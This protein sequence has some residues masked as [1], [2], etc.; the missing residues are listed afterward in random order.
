MNTRSVAFDIQHGL[1]TELQMAF[2]LLPDELRVAVAEQLVRLTAT[3]GL[4]LEEE[5]RATCGSFAALSSCCRSV[6]RALRESSIYEEVACRAKARASPQDWTSCSPFAL[7]CEREESTRQLVRTLDAGVSSLATHCASNHCQAARKSLNRDFLAC[8]TELAH[9]CARQVVLTGSR[10]FLYCTGDR[11]GSTS[12]WI[13]A[14]DMTGTTVWSP[15]SELRQVARV[16]LSEP[17]IAMRADESLLVFSTQ[18]GVWGW[19]SE[20]QPWRISAPVE[21]MLVSDF[22]VSRGQP[23]LM[24]CS[25]DV[26]TNLFLHEVDA[27]VRSVA[28]HLEEQTVT[29]YANETSGV[30][31]ALR[32]S[33]DG[34]T[35]LT[36]ASR[37]FERAAVQVLDVDEDSEEVL[38]TEHGQTVAYCLSPGAQSACVFTLGINAMVSVFVRLGKDSWTRA[39][40]VRVPE[41]PCAFGASWPS[42]SKRTTEAV[43]SSCGSKVLFYGPRITPRPAICSLDM[44]RITRR[45]AVRVRVKCC[46]HEALPRSIRLSHAGILMQTHRGALVIRRSPHVA[47]LRL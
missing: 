25:E 41:Q 23:R 15:S 37:A 17:L 45:R 34:S 36:M 40:Y 11:K 6:N 39:F 16:E 7:Q 42:V 22:W 14:A 28:V 9:S 33:A 12:K 30:Y 4:A 18:E 47:T 29:R 1:G 38:L 10:A 8:R 20:G 13:V 32:P 31:S 26:D 19:R 24:L 21:G 44:G 43:F 46:A 3:S 27:G 2:C 35:V 5:V